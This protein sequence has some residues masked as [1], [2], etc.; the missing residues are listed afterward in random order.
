MKIMDWGG[1][2]TDGEDIFNDGIAGLTEMVGKRNFHLTCKISTLLLQI[3]KHHWTHVLEKNHAKKNYMKRHN[4]DFVTEDRSE[5]MDD[6]L[7]RRIIDESFAK[8]ESECRNILN[9][10]LKEYRPRDIAD[11]LGISYTNLR[12]RKSRCYTALR[13][14]VDSHP[15]YKFLIESGEINP[16]HKSRPNE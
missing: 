4:E 12:L 15:D 9:A 10:Y 13:Q 14:I 3:C 6:A 2:S 8:L 7:K 5:E 1:T 16:D 11:I